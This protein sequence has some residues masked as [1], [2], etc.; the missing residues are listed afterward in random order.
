MDCRGMMLLSK[1]G[2]Q[3]SQLLG[4]R[5]NFYHQYAQHDFTLV[6]RR[7]GTLEELRDLTDAAHARGMYVL[8]APWLRVAFMAIGS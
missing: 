4:Y 1:M 5:F 3:G 7:L 6:D 2:I 8:V